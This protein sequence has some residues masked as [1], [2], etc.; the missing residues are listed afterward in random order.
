MLQKGALHTT[1]R[2]LFCLFCKP[3]PPTAALKA[4]EKPSRDLDEV[5]TWHTW[6]SLKPHI[7]I[8][9]E[10]YIVLQ[11]IEALFNKTANHWLFLSISNA[12]TCQS[13]CKQDRLFA[14]VVISQT[15]CNIYTGGPRSLSKKK[16]KETP[17]ST[18]LVS[19]F[20]VRFRV[21]RPI[22]N[23]HLRAASPAFIW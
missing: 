21:K 17:P 5:S 20:N 15:P 23:I 19:S 2:S 1:R 18:A 11:N 9:V 13:V 8:I 4:K 3:C 12:M 14:N 22:R 6:T 16:L 7:F 10:K